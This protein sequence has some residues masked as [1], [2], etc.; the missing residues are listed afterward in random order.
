MSINCRT[1]NPG[2]Q[3]QAENRSRS[4]VVLSSKLPLACGGAERL[5]H[6]LTAQLR[7]CG[8]QCDLFF[9]PQQPFNRQARGYLAAMTT[10]LTGDVHGRAVDRIISLRYPAYAVRHHDHR[11]WLTHRVREYYDLW[12]TMYGSLTSRWSRA[13]AQ[14]K[15]AAIHGVDRWLLS[16]G[17]SKVYCISRYGAQQLK[18]WG[19][20]HADVLYPP[21]PERSYYCGEFSDTIL[22]VS[23]LH[24]TKRL[25]L[26]IAAMSKLKGTAITGL[27]IGAGEEHE[28]LQRM[29]KYEGLAGQ[30]RILTEVDDATLTR[31]Y[32]DSF[33][34]Y[35]APFQEDY[36]FVT[37]EAYKSGKP[38][39]TCTDSGG[40]LE[41]VRDGENGYIV[42]PKV[43]SIAQRIQRLW[44]DKDS[45]RSMGQVGFQSIAPITWNTVLDHLGGFA[46]VS[47]GESN[48]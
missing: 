39:I 41:F 25:D 21:P 31:Y 48:Q 2:F 5:A 44:H 34:V 6:E 26:F 4:I 33:A 1:S 42:E 3:D 9:L 45:A 30:V 16:H 10:T 46:S 17:I 15:R 28:R 36:G 40:P 37:L 32:A 29:I 23:R 43:D 12:P 7:R 8:H 13:L 19:S 24:R 47:S 11:V 18:T 27:I 20:I 14:T 38:V 35:F 22:A